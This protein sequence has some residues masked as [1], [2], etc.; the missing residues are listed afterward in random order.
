MSIK[1]RNAG[2]SLIEV[3]IALLILGVGILGF[4][5]MQNYALQSNL[6]IEKRSRIS[7]MATEIVE[8]MTLAGDGGSSFCT[9]TTFADLMTSKNSEV[10][11]ALV[12]T[13]STATGTRLACPDNAPMQLTIVWDDADVLNT[14]GTPNNQRAMTMEIQL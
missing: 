9:G 14:S 12:F 2:F 1:Q 13:D 10:D 5:S 8:R 6:G 4:L 7:M 3:L 11:S